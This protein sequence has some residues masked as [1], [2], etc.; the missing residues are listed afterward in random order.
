MKL[1]NLEL[2]F[3]LDCNLQRADIN[4]LPLCSSCR[5]FMYSQFYIKIHNEVDPEIN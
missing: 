1:I 3:C 5:R 2:Y 4:A